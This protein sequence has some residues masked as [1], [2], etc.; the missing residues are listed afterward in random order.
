MLATK[1]ASLG[2]EVKVGARDAGNEKAAA[3]AGSA[4][5]SANNAKQRA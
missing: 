2:H 5:A 1:L 3:W 4:G